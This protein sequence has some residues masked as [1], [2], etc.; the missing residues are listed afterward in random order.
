MSTS[1]YVLRYMRQEDITQVLDIDHLSF[2]LP[3]S[4]RSYTFEITDNNHSHM[5]SLALSDRKSSSAGWLGAL[6][7]LRNGS[8]AHETIVGYGGFWL[9]D[10][11]AHISTIAVHPHYRGKGL[12]ELLLAGMLGRG[13][14]LDAEYSVLEVRVGNEPAI[15]LYRKYEYEIA[16]RRKN[17]YRD[18][19]EDAF[20][21][22]LAPLSPSYK[23]RFA[24]RLEQLHQRLDYRD[25]FTLRP[26]R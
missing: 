26:A 4:A 17:Y 14:A 3:W 20:L 22:N 21:M 8:H 12:G 11:E 1:P 6:Q 10:G 25:Q 9:I 13:M 16:G 19:G 15:S 23:T 5:V 2:P 24:S 18:N 7:R